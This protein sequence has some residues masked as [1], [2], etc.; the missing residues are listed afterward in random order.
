MTTRADRSELARAMAKA[1]AY[2]DCGKP[3]MAA[4]RAALLIFKVG[5]RV[6][7][8]DE[9]GLDATGTVTKI[10]PKYAQVRWDDPGIDLR[11]SVA[12]ARKSASTYPIP[13]KY[14]RLL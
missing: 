8:T 14:L 2:R 1:I 9:L 12:V 10:G 5:S 7:R 11:R 3:E 4:R 13:Y 6:A